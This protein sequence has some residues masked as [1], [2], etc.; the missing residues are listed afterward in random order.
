MPYFFIIMK[1]ILIKILSYG[2]L[3][4]IILFYVNRVNILNKDLSNAVNNVKAYEAE[5]SNLRENNQT[6]KLTIQNMKKSQDSLMLKMKQVANENG[7][8]DKE[9]K[10]LQYQLEHFKKTDTVRLVD[11][12]FRDKGFILDTCM[13]DKWNSTCLHLE[14]PNLISITNEYNNEKY[15][16]L[17]SHKEPIKDRKWFLPRWFTKKHTVVEV[18]VVDENP[19][20]TTKEQRFVEIID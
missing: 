2:I 20:V 3:I 19:Y 1:N 14:Y 18:T 16:I 11:T 8:K 9:I 7:I 4:S 17:D 12:I 15:I 13:I 10:S 6:F 5:N